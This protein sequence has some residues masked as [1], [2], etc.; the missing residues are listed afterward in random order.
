MRIIKPSVE[1]LVNTNNTTHV[2]KCAR[3]C[4]AG[5]FTSDAKDEE[6]VNTLINSEHLSM[7]R[8]GTNYYVIPANLIEEGGSSLNEFYNDYYYNPFIAHEDDVENKV[9]LYSIN[10][11]FIYENV[12]IEELLAP[13]LVTEEEFLRYNNADL[14]RRFSFCCVTQ[15]STSRELNRISPNNIVEESTRYCNYSQDKF[16]NEVTIVNHIGLICLLIAI[17][18]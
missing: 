15:I 16:S 2:A 13:Y 10:L 1:L 18:F 7:L 6:L 9:Y 11:Q 5:R 12:D 14:I 17:K 8:H 3:I 4:R